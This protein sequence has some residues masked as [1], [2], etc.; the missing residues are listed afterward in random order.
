[1]RH[2]WYSDACDRCW[3]VVADLMSV[4][5]CARGLEK[6]HIPRNEDAPSK[7]TWLHAT[8]AAG[9]TRLCLLL[10]QNKTFS[11]FSF[12]K[13]IAAFDLN[14]CQIKSTNVEDNMFTVQ[15]FPSITD[16]NGMRLKSWHFLENPVFGPFDAR[17]YYFYQNRLISRTATSALSFSRFCPCI[18]NCDNR[19]LYSTIS[20]FLSP[21]RVDNWNTWINLTRQWNRI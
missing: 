8:L 6:A 12:E 20:D 16:G 21:L 7:I 2:Q 15:W 3:P 19:G 17:R 9:S 18:F 13:T 1:M 14:F 10:Y 5:N 4:G 11:T